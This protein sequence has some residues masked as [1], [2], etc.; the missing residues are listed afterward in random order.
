MFSIYCCKQ[1]RCALLNRPTKVR[2]FLQFSF[3]S[4]TVQCV[5]AFFFSSF[6]F[7][8]YFLYEMIGGARINSNKTQHV[9]QATKLNEPHIPTWHIAYNFII[10]ELDSI[11]TDASIDTST[12]TA[13]KHWTFQLLIRIYYFSN[14]SLTHMHVAHNQVSVCWCCYCCCWIALRNRATY[15]IHSA[16]AIVPITLAALQSFSTGIFPSHQTNFNSVETCARSSRK[17]VFYFV[18]FQFLFFT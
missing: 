10:Y 4:L 15:S 17:S 3:H 5:T 9:C 18:V 14:A 13:T 7:F 1:L 11:E 8:P 16:T 12:S 6:Q 2:I